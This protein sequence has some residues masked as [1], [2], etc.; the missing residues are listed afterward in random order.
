[1]INSQW[2][3]LNNK[4]YEYE[5]LVRDAN[6]LLYTPVAAE[7]DKSLVYRILSDGSKLQV[8]MRWYRNPQGCKVLTNVYLTLI[9][10]GVQ[11]TSQINVDESNYEKNWKKNRKNGNKNN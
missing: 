6:A 4:N 11:H 9:K 3:F 7:H 10:D 1:M 2:M 8:D 5:Q